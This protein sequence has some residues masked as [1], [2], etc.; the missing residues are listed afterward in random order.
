VAFRPFQYNG[1]V[2][3]DNGEQDLTRTREGY[4]EIIEMGVVGEIIDAAATGAEAAARHIDTNA[5]GRVDTPADCSVLT[6][7]W[8][9]GIWST[10]ADADLA[11]PAGGLFGSVAILN[12][13][14]GVEYSTNAVALENWRNTLGGVNQVVTTD[15]DGV[16]VAV[17]DSSNSIHVDT[18]TESPTLA[19]ASPETSGVYTDGTLFTADWAGTTPSGGANAV[20][21][22]MMVKS[23]ANE[24]TIN[25]AVGAA[26]DWI[27]TFP[28]KRTYTNVN[29]DLLVSAPFTE[30]FN[31]DTTPNGQACEQVAIGFWD[32]EEASETP[33]PGELDFSPQLPEISIIEALCFEANVLTFG[34]SDVFSA[35][36]PKNIDIADGFNN[37]WARITFS[38]NNFFGDPATGIYEGLPAIGFAASRLTNNG[39]GVGAAYAATNDHRAIRV[40]SG[41]PL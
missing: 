22:T 20:T 34:D 25:P 32:R 1:G 4:V 30:A 24:Y 31:D 14:E 11:Q 19:N 5:D 28:G 13:Q 23:L 38:D 35:Q 33:T 15:G 7:L 16:I 2:A 39:V 3:L 9:G 21:A 10:N 6:G 37:G 36:D 27:V 17:S 8:N 18:G 29:D 12:I 40:I 26:T 41:A